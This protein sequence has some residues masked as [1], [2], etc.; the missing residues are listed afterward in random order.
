MAWFKQSLIF[1]TGVYVVLATVGVAHAADEIHWTF[2]GQTSV[3]LDWRGAAT[4]D[5]V[6]YG[7]S[8]GA[9]TEIAIAQTP[10]PLPF[11]SPGPF[12]EA[13]I[14]GLAED[15]LYYYSVAG[16]P[17]HTFRT[18]PPRGNSNFTVFAEGDIG[19]SGSYSRMPLV[20]DLIA[21]GNPNFVLVPGDLAYGNIHGQAAVD[22]HFNDVMVWSQDAA[23]MPAWGNHEWDVPASDD[24]RNYK[25]R[26]AFPNP[27]TS[28]NAPIE[29]C[30]GEDW[31][32]FDYGNVRFISYPDVGAGSGSPDGRGRS[33]SGYRFHRNLWP[34]AGPFV[35]ATTRRGATAHRPGQPGRQLQQ[36]RSEYQR[37]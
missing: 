18:P 12:W 4:E 13:A 6:R 34:S 30:C 31:Y 8:P 37:P 3:T 7:T 28:P 29:G 1:C 15:T 14:T 17:E 9:Y 24:L 22:Q 23:Y 25:G 20:Q 35:R 19:D 11:S 10:T 32:W 21:E 33:G 27:Q 16:G 2:T 26:F 5:Y 36:I